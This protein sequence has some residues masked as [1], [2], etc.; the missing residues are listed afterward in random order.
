M[1]LPPHPCYKQDENLIIHLHVHP[2]S[3]KDEWVGPHG[4]AFKVKIKAPP[5]DGKANLYLI[6]LLADLFGVKKSAVLLK[7]GL[8]SK[9]KTFLIKRP[10]KFPPD[11]A[12]L[13]E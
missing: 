10:M 2:G 3:K 5:V 6:A 8:S 7:Q 12:V 9:E 13:L 4:N 1:S 11:V